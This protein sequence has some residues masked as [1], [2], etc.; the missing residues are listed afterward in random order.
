V[1]CVS[2]ATFGI[3]SHFIFIVSQIPNGVDFSDMDELWMYPLIYA[4]IAMVLA[5]FG[6][7]IKTK[8]W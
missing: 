8:T 1:L 2:F 3:F 6:V 7:F 5:L 4:L